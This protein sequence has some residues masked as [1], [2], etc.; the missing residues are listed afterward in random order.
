MQAV[1][2]LLVPCKPAARPG[3][4]AG[5]PGAGAGGRA[6]APRR[7]AARRHLG[8]G[9]ALPLARHPGGPGR[10]QRRRLLQPAAGVRLP[11]AHQVRGGWGKA[12]GGGGRGGGGKRRGAAGALERWSA[13][14]LPCSP[15]A[16][17]PFS[18]SAGCQ[19]WLPA[20]SWPGCRRLTPSS[21]AAAQPLAGTRMIAG[22]SAAGPTQPIPNRR[23]AP[24]AAPPPAAGP[25]W[26]PSCARRSCGC[27]RA[28]AC[29]AWPSQPTGP[30]GP[31]RT[32]L[33]PILAARGPA[34]AVPAAE[35]LSPGNG[36]ATS[37]MHGLSCGAVMW[38]CRRPATRAWLSYWCG[39]DR[40][41]PALLLQCWLPRAC[42]ARWPAS[43]PSSTPAWASWWAQRRAVLNGAALRSCTN[44]AKSSCKCSGRHAARAPRLAPS[45]PGPTF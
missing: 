41:T 1:P 28:C 33:V 15:A 20:W 30:P 22:S 4:G 31:P 36:I 2:A 29:W 37:F 8:P 7:P 32:G 39:C 26:P 42:C 40:T 38:G 12:R 19:L 11:G 23:Q 43:T 21:Q 18:P 17:L 27:A 16:R 45:M 10:R 13:R 6:A 25:W 14:W 3:Q 24:P 35:G 9:Q 5:W 44:A 34:L